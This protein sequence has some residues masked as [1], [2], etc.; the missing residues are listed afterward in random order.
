[1]ERKTIREGRNM[2]LRYP[3]SKTRVAKTL[4]SLFPSFDE[5]REPF[6]GGASIFFNLKPKKAWLNDVNVE[7]VNLLV[8]IKDNVN[9]I[10]I[11]YDKYPKDQS[12]LKALFNEIKY[13]AEFSPSEY[14]FINRTSFGGRTNH[15]PQRLSPSNVDQW[16]NSSIKKL[17]AAAVAL[18]NTKITLGDYQPLIDA[19]ADNAFLLLDPP[20]YRN[21]ELNNND[22]LYFGNFTVE[23]HIRLANILKTCKHKFLMTY[24]NHPFIT[25]L[26]K[27]FNIMNFDFKYCLSPLKKKQIG[28]ELI[29]RNY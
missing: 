11:E 19:P 9:D 21:T 18:K 27:D 29:I 28:R 2:L 20:Y 17:T 6:C 24:D 4:I 23:D 13:K 26:Y 3:G 10:L 7:L 12:G 25:D 8:K 1:M 16:Q 15:L 14:Y 22:K 5:Y